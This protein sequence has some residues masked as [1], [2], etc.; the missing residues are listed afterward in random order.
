VIDPS[1][2]SDDD[3]WQTYFLFGFGF[4]FEV[5]EHTAACPRTTEL[6]RAVPG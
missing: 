6:V 1:C 2:V 3:R 5:V 4:G